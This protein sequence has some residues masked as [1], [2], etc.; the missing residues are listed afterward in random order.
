[1]EM[2]ELLL[3]GADINKSFNN[4]PLGWILQFCEPN[5]GKMLELL[6]KYKYHA[7]HLNRNKDFEYLLI[8]LSMVQE[9]TAL[10]VL[11]RMKRHNF[12]M[13]DEQDKILRRTN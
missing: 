3:K 6:F 8:E 12:K 4:Q 10:Y 2:V 13:S 7:L 1:M 11:N 9:E 5:L